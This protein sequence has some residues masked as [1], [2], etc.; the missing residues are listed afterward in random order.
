MLRTTLH[1]IML[2]FVFTVTS[3]A[4]P[5]LASELRHQF[6]NPNFG[7]NPFN[8]QPLLNSAVLQNSFEEAETSDTTV[9]GDFQSRLDRAILNRLSREVVAEVFGEE[10]DLQAGTFNTGNFE[11]EISEDV[12][13]VTI[14]IV[15]TLTG[16]TTQ[17]QVPFF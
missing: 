12:D 15:D 11:V 16:D 5:L 1:L 4:S 7:G 10:S 14:G 8:A 2:L 6:I 9:L 3:A 17:I 13:G